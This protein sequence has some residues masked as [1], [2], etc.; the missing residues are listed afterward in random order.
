MAYTSN[1]KKIC[2]YLSWRPT[3]SSLCVC[4]S[5]CLTPPTNERLFSSIQARVHLRHVLM[6]E[7]GRGSSCAD[8]DWLV[9][10]FTAY[11]RTYIVMRA[12]TAKT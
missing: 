10:V 9:Y 6:A 3:Q 1:R 7:N 5:V 4:E 8:N 2:K 12:N 11:V